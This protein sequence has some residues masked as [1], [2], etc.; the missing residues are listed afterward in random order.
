[1]IRNANA[2]R[3][4]CFVAIWLIGGVS[5]SNAAA[6][7][8]I[9][10]NLL[11]EKQAIALNFAQ[12]I[13]RCVSKDDTNHSAFRG[14]IDWHSSVHGNW[15]LLA[16]Q[17]ATGNNEYQSL[18]ESAL[19]PAKIAEEQKLIVAEPSF[20]MPYGRAWFLR[21]AMQN[22]KT[23]GNS[24]LRQMA[25]TTLSSMIKY[26]QNREIDLLSG[27]YDSATWA[28]TNMIDYA[29]FTGNEQSLHRLMGKIESQLK[30]GPQRCD[31]E[32]ENGQFMAVC[33]NIAMLAARVMPHDR[34]QQWVVE[35]FRRNGIPK[36]VTDPKAWHHYGLNFSRAWGLWDCYNL[37]GQ[38]KFLDAFVSHFNA[39]YKPTSN[40]NGDYHG[41]G[42][43]VSQ[44]GVFALQPL[45]PNSGRN[46]LKVRTKD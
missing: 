45:F 11:K 6:V 32:I 21:L 20:E 46:L 19:T 31:Y 24:A 12:T 33:T 26:Y 16:I 35:F 10:L 5:V 30:S 43:W 1:M 28:L 9:L 7:P 36:P 3:R 40:W 15:A 13:S 37:T 27:S 42:H 2:I 18:V 34:Y 17:S 8:D 38:L 41:V 44:F 22:E 39:G 23:L 14:C 25:D 4:C 29:R